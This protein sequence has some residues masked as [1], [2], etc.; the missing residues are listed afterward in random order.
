MT[1]SAEPSAQ[2]A[3]KLTRFEEERVLAKPTGGLAAYEYIL[4]GRE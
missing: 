2:M 4:R 1:S 3:V